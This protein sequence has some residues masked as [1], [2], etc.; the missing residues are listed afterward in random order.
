MNSDFRVQRMRTYWVWGP[1]SSPKA[2]SQLRPE[3][4]RVDQLKRGVMW[5]G[6]RISERNT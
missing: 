2:A 6:L 4:L 5:V 3:G 1:D